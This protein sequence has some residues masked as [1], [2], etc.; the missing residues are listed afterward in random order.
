MRPVDRNFIERVTAGLKPK[1]II[2][3]VI[4][5]TKQLAPH[6]VLCVVIALSIIIIT[7]QSCRE[8]KHKIIRVAARV[9][10]ILSTPS[11]AST[12][13]KTVRIRVVHHG[14]E[15][16]PFWQDVH[17]GMMD[18]EALLSGIK[19]ERFANIDTMLNNIKG[20]PENADGLI[21]SCPYINTNPK[22]KEIDEAII[23]VIES[24]NPVITFNTDTYHNRNVF[25][26][27]G[28]SNKILGKRG[29]ITALKKYT[30][31]MPEGAEVT[32]ESNNLSVSCEERVKLL[33]KQCKL[34]IGKRKISHVIGFLQEKFNV[35]LDWRIEEFHKEWNAQTLPFSPT[36]LVKV[37]T[38]EEARAAISAVKIN[39][40]WETCIVVPTGL[41]TMEPATR[42]K[43]SQ[44]DIYIC[45]VGD[46]GAAVS[47]LGAKHDVPFVGQMQYQQGFAT[48][49][50]MHN[51][52]VNYKG[53]TAWEREKGNSA[54]TIDASYECTENCQTN[55]DDT[56]IK[57]KERG[58]NSPWIQIGVAVQLEGL[59]IS[60][61]DEYQ[62]TN[63]GKINKV[64]QPNGSVKDSVVIDCAKNYNAVYAEDYSVT[65]SKRMYNGM[66][67]ERLKYFPL[68][69]RTV[70][71][72][73]N[74]CQ[75]FVVHS[76]GTRLPLGQAIDKVLDGTFIRM[77]LSST[78]YKIM[79]YDQDDVVQ[80]QLVLKGSLGNRCAPCN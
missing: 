40:G 46:T 78:T 75:Y 13:K 19:V 72:K 7:I 10:S 52:I 62:K 45:E 24:G 3:L 32:S 29:A 18:A 42:L 23:G 64:I 21:V 2:A 38:F 66:V 35:T 59:D 67:G 22:Y 41:A 53:G 73:R 26:Y 74:K 15:Q 39:S 5:M 54:L 4:I 28:S 57:K 47:E 69:E 44:P 56:A 20:A 12:C 25:Q 27:V 9:S 50:S 1:K 37:Y 36:V 49:T 71:G 77:Q 48:I 43:E 6:I 76:N 65:D 55:T 68:Y 16:D 31:L 34:Q 60:K 58:F 79:L 80:L 17:R 14:T 51:L 63:I 33:E 61:W 8:N 11:V 30:N 70:D